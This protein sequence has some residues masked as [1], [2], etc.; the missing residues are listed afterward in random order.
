MRNYK[1]NLIVKMTFQF[2]LD[3]I[4]FAER[5]RS[6]KRS[7]FSDQVLRSGCSIGANVKEAQGAE[8]KA[9]FIHKMKIAI[10][11]AEETEYWLELCSLSKK[12]PQPGQLLS[13]IE[14][15]LKIINKII[16][17]SKINKSLAN[18]AIDN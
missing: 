4:D 3:I 14:S 2:A 13:D 7:A 8:S 6:E 15:I 11:E 10:K 17:T 16:S 9:D 1:D 18:K 5:L 12:Y